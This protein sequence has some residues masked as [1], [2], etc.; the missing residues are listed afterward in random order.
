M[1]H[2]TPIQQLGK[3][4][5]AYSLADHLQ[6]NPVFDTPRGEKATFD[7]VKVSGFPLILL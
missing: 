1:L 4:N 7:G 6:L 5:S 3:S 2:F